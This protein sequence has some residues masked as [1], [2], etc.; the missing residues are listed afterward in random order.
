MEYYLYRKR[1]DYK[2]VAKVKKFLIDSKYID[3]SQ[4]ILKITELGKKYYKQQALLTAIKKIFDNYN[5]YLNNA[6]NLAQK[7]PKPEGDKN[8]ARQI[9]EIA[10][11]NK[12]KSS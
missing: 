2:W 1:I 11:N 8:A 10:T 3:D 5:L 9:F 6:H 4:K 12:N 7:L